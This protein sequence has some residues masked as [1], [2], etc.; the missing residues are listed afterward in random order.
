LQGR[1]N[2]VDGNYFRGNANDVAGTSDMKANTITNNKGLLTMA[3]GGFVFDPQEYNFVHGNTPLTAVP[4]DNYDA[5]AV[6]RARNIALFPI[7]AWMSAADL[8]KVFSN[9]AY[10]SLTAGLK[11]VS[12]YYKIPAN[13]KKITRFT[14]NGFSD[15][16]GDSVALSVVGINSPQSINSFPLF[17]NMGTQASV[18]LGDFSFAFG[19]TNP[20]YAN[21]TYYISIVFTSTSFVTQLRNVGIVALCDE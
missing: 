6:M 10:L 2:I 11:S 19:A 1:H 17:Q 9:G 12:L 8:A 14:V 5:H 15:T 3:V 20:F 16:I 18:A 7:D 13:V 21:G 4:F